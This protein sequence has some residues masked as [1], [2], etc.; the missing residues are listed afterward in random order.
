M[1][2][3]EK[4]PWDLM[5]EIL[6]RVPPTSLLRFRTV[7]KR[8]N[9]LFDDNAF[10]NNHKMT[11]RFIVKSRTKIYSVNVS[12]K[13]EVRELT[14]NTPGLK[15]QIP[16]SLV[17]TSGF[18]LC[19]M[20]NGVVVWNPWL[21]QIRC[22][23]PEINQPTLNFHGIGYDNNRRDDEIVYKTLSTYQK[24]LDSTTTCKCKIY[25]FAS[26]TWKDEELEKAK[27]TTLLPSTSS[28]VVVN[29]VSLNGTL[30]WVAYYD[31]THVTH[32]LLFILLSFSFSSEN[33]RKC[34]DLPSGENHPRDALFREDGFLLLK[35]CHVNKKIK[36]W[37]TKNKIDDRYGENVKWMSFMEVSIPNMPDLVQTESYSQPSYFIDGK[38]LVI[39]SC[40]ENGR[41]WIY[42]V[43]ENKLISK[44][45]LDS[46]VDPWPL[47]C[48]YFPSLVLIP[49]GKR[50]KL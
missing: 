23:E 31:R 44:T 2:N 19:G 43:R 49:G 20:R 24:D 15:P 8:W 50:E 25:D 42:V 4:V 9:S 18:L 22:I 35:Q 21:R 33:F 6:S 14:L 47:H 5:E 1:A 38:R 41:A 26:D 36:I 12:S 10:I 17:D 28:L 32:P 16:R 39:C 30:Y 37:V 48:T 27:Y 3:T 46:V 45:Q 29:V 34:C 40:D 7:C 11:F 13:V